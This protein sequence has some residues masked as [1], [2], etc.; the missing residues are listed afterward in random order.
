PETC[1]LDQLDRAPVLCGHAREPTLDPIDA[2][3]VE[4]TSDLELLLR[5]ED[6]ADGLLPV[7]ERRVVEAD[8]PADAHL[9]VQLPGPDLVAH[10]TYRSSRSGSCRG[11]RRSRRVRRSLIGTHSCPRCAAS[12]RPCS[13]AVGTTSSRSTQSEKIV[14]RWRYFRPANS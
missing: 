7:A 11:C 8:V 1:A 14:S 5:V 6:D 12:S 3:L 4:Q 2:E 13:S 9:V 10:A